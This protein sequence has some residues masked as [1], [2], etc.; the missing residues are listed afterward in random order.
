MS[1]IIFSI[2]VVNDDTTYMYPDDSL[3]L[4]S[5]YLWKDYNRLHE[6]K[7]DFKNIYC[8]ISNQGLSST[9]RK[10]M[11]GGAVG[12]ALI[13]GLGVPALIGGLAGSGLAGGAAIMSGLATLGGPLGTL[14]GLIVA[15]MIGSISYKSGEKI[16][17]I[18]LNEVNK[19][20]IK[21]DFKKLSYN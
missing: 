19:N 18:T 4:S 16:S 5:H 10:L 20:K 6:I 21:D 15:S 1:K 13:A 17:Y 9:Q 14:G 7:E 3:R 12:I 8:K 2:K 11:I